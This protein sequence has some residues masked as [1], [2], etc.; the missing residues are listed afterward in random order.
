MMLKKLVIFSTL[1][2]VFFS[3]SWSLFR[4]DFFYVHDFTHAARIVEMHKA[5]ADGHF[6]VRWSSDFAF[7]YGM[8]LFEFYAPL[9]YYAG[10]IFYWIG[11]SLVDSIKLLMII[12]T[13]VTII[14]SYKLGKILFGSTGGLLVSAAIT[15]APYRAVNL[16]VRGA[17]SELWGIMVLPFILYGIVKIIKIERE[18]NIFKVAII[19]L[20]SLVTLLLSH[21][22][23]SLIFLPLSIV[24]G[25]VY[26][27]IVSIDKK[28]KKEFILK[29]IL[30]L[31]STYFLSILISSFY[32]FP[33]IIEKGFTKVES[34]IVGN[35]FDYKLH[36]LYFRQFFEANWKYGGS[37]W[38]P[39]D[40]ISFYLGAGQLISLLFLFYIFAKK[41]NIKKLSSTFEKKNYLFFT[42]VGLMMISIFMT[43]GHSK[44]IWD[45]INI[46]AF[47]QFP[48][49]WLSAIIIF[50]GL[51]IGFIP[52]YIQNKFK[53]YC[54]FFLLFF[55]IIFTNFKY[56]QPEKYLVDSSEYYY[57][58]QN[59]IRS[60]M[61]KTL[62]DY[63]PQQISDE[64]L[65]PTVE[66]GTMLMC[67]VFQSG[68]DN[69]CSFDYEKILDKTHKKILKVNLI[70]AQTID[71]SLA[72]YPGWEAFIDGEKINNIVSN[73]G[74][75]SLSIP[76]G[77]HEIM[78]IFKDTKVRL[79]SDILSISGLVILLLIYFWYY[80]HND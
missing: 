12:S 77:T 11:F 21:N 20:V 5:L 2:I 37:T 70:N 16:F 73:S 34:L 49:R 58:D 68:I 71:F 47:I 56:F 42:T 40:D 69:S 53:R 22:L 3:S 76:S 44:I 66:T 27:F 55:V 23:T 75:I 32:L 25:A 31:A 19:L 39:N 8:P 51:S 24:F 45:S 61:S 50:A 1:L 41:I 67:E 18:K 7:G 36:F 28:N 60:E 52:F 35:Y 64:A 72:Y 46:L 4:S 10:S 14:G 74:K 59:R 38:G 9:P 54:L 17:I 29:R 63:I 80:K 30:L 43:L 6:P 13:L 48:W 15:L 65:I 33:T 78:L 62:P 26:L 79:I 57:S